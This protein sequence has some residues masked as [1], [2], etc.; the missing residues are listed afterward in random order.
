MF[1]KIEAADHQTFIQYC[2]DFY[3]SPAVLHKVP[4]S[5]FEA[6]FA[7]LMRGDEYLEGYIFT[8]NGENL[9][10]ALLSKSFSPEVGGR[11]ILVE[12]IY[13]LEAARGKGIAS[14]FFA[15]LDRRG[16]KR[17]RLEYEH[18]NTGAVRLYKRLGFSELPYG[19]MVKDF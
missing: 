11:L 13:I 16:A 8:D 1:R 4:D 18:S 17:I 15:Y 5:V 6:T 2:R 9:G 10:Y 14:E 7:E 12:E 3:S 19:Q